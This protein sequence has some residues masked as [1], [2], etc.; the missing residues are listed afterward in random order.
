MTSTPRHRKRSIGPHYED[1]ITRNHKGVIVHSSNWTIHLEHEEISDVVTDNYHKRIAEGE[2]IN[3]PCVYGKKGVRR[4][5]YPTVGLTNLQSGNKY[6]INGGSNTLRLLEVSRLISE[7]KTKRELKVLETV[8]KEAKLRALSNIDRTPYAFGED[9]GEIRETLK[10]ISRPLASLSDLSKSFQKD[11][12]KSRIRDKTKAQADVWNTYR[13]AASPL[14][15]SIYSAYEA[16]TT[17]EDT[18][19]ERLTA[20]GFSKNFDVVSWNSERANAASTYRFVH[21]DSADIDGHASILYEITNPMR[22]LKFKLGLRTKDLPLTAWQLV[23]LSFMIDRMVDLSSSIGGLVALTDPRIR[24]LAASYREKRLRSSSVTAV[25]WTDPSWA[26]NM[27]SDTYT[28][29]NFSYIRNPWSP[30]FLD[31]I[32]QVKTR[33]LIEDATKTVDL[34]NI[35][36]S[37]LL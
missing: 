28:T 27:A 31:L 16:A 17:D 21:N 6:T 4:E 34:I 18:L 11:V 5:T 7:T 20:R 1:R 2:I 15:R 13:F 19:P 3:N 35:L 36:I 32:P 26:V 33:G 25:S 9:V 10:F 24:I 30:S 12:K 23:P 8:E 29:E 37:R 14:V 22:F